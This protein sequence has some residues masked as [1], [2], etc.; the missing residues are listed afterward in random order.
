MNHKNSCPLCNENHPFRTIEYSEIARMDGLVVDYIAVHYECDRVLMDDDKRK[1]IQ[2]ENEKRVNEALRARKGLLTAKQIKTL[3]K[4]RLHLSVEDL[5]LIIGIGE[6]SLKRYE[7]AGGNWQSGCVNSVLRMFDRDL[8]SLLFCLE[9]QKAAFSAD[10]YMKLK[11]HIICL[12]E[13]NEN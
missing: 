13:N 7:V 5:A 9:C 2:K 8:R 10:Q 3:R 6:A 11:D 12:I 1:I 4:N